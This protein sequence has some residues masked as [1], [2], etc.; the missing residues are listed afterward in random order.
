MSS[1]AKKTPPETKSP[2]VVIRHTPYGSSM[3]R[4]SLDTVLAFAAFDQPVNVLFLAE[5][6][7]QLISGQDGK[8]IDGK[9]LA[10]QIGSL[11]LYGVKT[12]YAE[13]DAL[14]RFSLSIEELPSQV[15]CVGKEKIRE[16]IAAHEHVLSF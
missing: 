11:P 1:E 8:A 12:F 4:S 13:K 3:A 10:K 14:E 2:L 5:G 6:V 16:L 9:T 7:L 15:C